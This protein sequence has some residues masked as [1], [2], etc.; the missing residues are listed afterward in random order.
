M[1]WLEIQFNSL[2]LETNFHELKDPVAFL[3]S[4]TKCEIPIEKARPKQEDLSKDLKKIRIGNKSAKKS[5]S[6]IN[7]LFNVRNDAIKFADDCGSIIL[8]AKKTQL[9]KGPEPEPL[10]VK[11]KRKKS[12]LE[13]H[14]EWW[15]SINEQIFKECFFIILH[16]FHQSNYIIAIK[17]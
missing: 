3:D 1:R 14:E 13:L 12:S 6:N 8:Q 9:I 5:L 15:K 10:K 16:Y 17:L 4:I 7:K 2:D 11:T